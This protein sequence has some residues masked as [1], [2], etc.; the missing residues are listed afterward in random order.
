L[1]P[2]KLI[3]A[4]INFWHAGLHRAL[5]WL[6]GSLDEEARPKD[7]VWAR[8]QLFNAR[9]RISYDDLGLAVKKIAAKNSRLH[10]TLKDFVL[11]IFSAS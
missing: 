1:Q 2:E 4:F 6:G 10:A 3:Q 11:E 7:R 5:V 8:A 9:Q